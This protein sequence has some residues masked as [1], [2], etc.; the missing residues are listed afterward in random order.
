M[1]TPLL[2]VFL[3][4]AGVIAVGLGTLILTVPV[5]FYASY[6]L[7][8]TGQV[9]LLDEMR[10]HGL[11]LMGIGLFVM[12]GAVIPRFATAA[13]AVSA[14]FYLSYGLSRLVGLALD[15]WPGQGLAISGAIELAVGALALLIY[16]SRGQSALP[17][18]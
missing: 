18:R 4:V 12:T 6:G 9:T 11:S 8:L 2:R 13:L 7:D 3:A 15:G 14:F 16:F 10:S 17:T 5:A 1:S